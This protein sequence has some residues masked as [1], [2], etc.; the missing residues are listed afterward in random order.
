MK[1][2]NKHSKAEIRIRFLIAG[3]LN[4]LVTSLI[5]IVMLTEFSPSVSYSISFV[6]GVLL[7]FILNSLAVFKAS[8]KWLNFI[9]FLLG[10]FFQYFIG[11]VTLY[12]LV[13]RLLY[14]P[15]HCI[16]GVIFLTVPI[17]FIF[18]KFVFTKKL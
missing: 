1:L 2:F 10:Y 16:I 8:L 7:S 12:F 6:I 11:Y 3:L 13:T 17:N 15:R 5:Y 18:N 9:Y 14:D 4:T